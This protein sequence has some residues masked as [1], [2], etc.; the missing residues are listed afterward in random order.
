MDFS[1]L[2]PESGSRNPD[3]EREGRR[4]SPDLRLSVER[5]VVGQVALKKKRE[6]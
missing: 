6:V 3:Y 2:R 5:L 4:T 1:W